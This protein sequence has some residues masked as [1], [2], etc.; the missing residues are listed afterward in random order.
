MWIK[1]TNKIMIIGSLLFALFLTGCVDEPTIAP[2][3]RPYSVIRVG[4]L[5]A[6]VD[7]ID[8]SIFDVELEQIE[9]FSLQRNVFTDYFTVP[10]GKRRFF[11]KNSVSGDTLFNKTIDITSYEEITV[12]FGGYYSA[13]IDTSSFSHFTFSEGMIYSY[14]APAPD[15]LFVFFINAVGYS[16]P[17]DTS[18]SLAVW[19]DTTA[20]TDSLTIIREL[21]YGKCFGAHMGAAT[22]NLS[23][24][25]EATKD[26]VATFSDEFSAGT[27]NFIY[28]SGTPSNYGIVKEVKEPLPIRDK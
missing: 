19:R 25:V 4:N 2:V 10:S 28:I 7:N 1:F 15:S 13:S 21:E 3:K 8:V 5:S 16:P 23:F 14:E 9:L 12:Y 6:N 26:T 18:K 22:Y 17:A 20:N 11:V 24:I 27:R